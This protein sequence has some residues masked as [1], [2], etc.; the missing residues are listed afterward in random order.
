[1]AGLF[2]SEDMHLYQLQV[3]NDDK[4]TVLDQLGDIGLCHFID[5][6]DGALPQKLDFTKRIKSIEESEKKLQYLLDQS[7]THY[8]EARKP[9]DCASFKDRIGRVRGI[10]DKSMQ[11]LLDD[12]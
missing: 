10:K 11:N 8:C 1:M 4:H 6:N 5:L 9:S 7:K 3:P 2:R 12:I